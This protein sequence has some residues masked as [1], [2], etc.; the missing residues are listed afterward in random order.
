MVRGSVVLDFFIFKKLVLH[1]L[2]QFEN[3][4]ENN[5]N[6]I[7]NT[8]IKLGQNIKKIIW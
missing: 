6:E 2:K 1:I 7:W 3:K 5:S 4:S 8:N